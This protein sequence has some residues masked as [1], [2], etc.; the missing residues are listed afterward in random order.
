ME[1]IARHK[2]VVIAPHNDKHILF[3]KHMTSEPHTLQII[4]ALVLAESIAHSALN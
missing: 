4:W 3:L 2:E 1:G